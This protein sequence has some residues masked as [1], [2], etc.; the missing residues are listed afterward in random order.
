MFSLMRQADK[1]LYHCACLKV[2]TTSYDVLAT[3]GTSFSSFF[4]YVIRILEI[5]VT[6]RV[7]VWLIINISH[8]NIL[9]ILTPRII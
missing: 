8:P 2:A 1:K 4:L 9:T 3:I 6:M 7:V 5:N